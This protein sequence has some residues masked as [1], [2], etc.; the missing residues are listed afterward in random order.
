MTPLFAIGGDIERG[1][2]VG[3]ATVSGDTKIVA[4][5]E[6]GRTLAFPPSPSSSSSS[7]TWAHPPPVQVIPPSG[8]F[9]LSHLTRLP[10]DKVLP[11]STLPGTRTPFRVSHELVMKLHFVYPDEEEERARMHIRSEPPYALCVTQ[12]IT[13]SSCSC[14]VKSLL[15]PS[16]EEALSAGAGSTPLT[17]TMS[18]TTP[19]PSVSGGRASPPP[20][21]PSY[22]P[23]RPSRSS[24]VSSTYAGSPAPTSTMPSFGYQPSRLARP[25]IITSSPAYPTPTPTLDSSIPPSPSSARALKQA[26]SSLPMGFSKTSKRTGPCICDATKEQLFEQ[27]RADGGFAGR[28]VGY[29]YEPRKAV[30]VPSIEREERVTTRVIDLV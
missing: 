16:Y 28:R 17:P 9:S 3:E 11:P 14:L 12:D 2:L 4:R 10:N 18:T 5:D 29:G 15:V 30:Y 26:L 22:L 7:S 27:D 20:S 25:T 13:I 19:R 24:S 1:K 6:N 21:Y 8:S 23:A